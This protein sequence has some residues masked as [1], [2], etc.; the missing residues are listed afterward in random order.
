M[1]TVREEGEEALVSTRA[2]TPLQPIK[3]MMVEQV[4]SCSQRRG[5]WCSRYILLPVEDPMPE[6]MDISR[7]VCGLR[8]AHGEE[9][10]S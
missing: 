6:L 10:L 4:F 3:E 9:C 2:D 5:P 7:K 8:R 1:Q